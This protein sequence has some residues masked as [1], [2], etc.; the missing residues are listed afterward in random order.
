MPTY[1]HPRSHPPARVHVSRGDKRPVAD[2]GTFDAPRQVAE[3]I[4]DH[5]GVSAAEMRVDSDDG[6]NESTGNGGLGVETEEPQPVCGATL[7]DGGTCTREVDAPEDRCWQ[8]DDA[9]D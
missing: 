1:R 7:S 9:D 3:S 8:H 5:H 4:A 6:S 2:D